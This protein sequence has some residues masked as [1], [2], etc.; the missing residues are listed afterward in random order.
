MNDQ[1]APRPPGPTGTYN[2]ATFEPLEPVTPTP[3]EEVAAVVELAREAQRGWAS[4]PFRERAD[5]VVSLARAVVERRA[6]IAGIAA[7]ESGRCETE[8]LVNE[9]ATNVTYA[10]SAVRAARGALAPETIK[11]PA[12][13]LPGKKVVVEAVPR[14]VIGIIAP[15]NYPLGNFF[16]SLYP[17][18]LAGDAAVLKPSSS[19]PRS[20]AWLA[21]LCAEIL[22]E[23]LV[24]IVQG[25]GAVAEALLDAGLDGVVFTGSVATG[26]RVAVKA[27]EL[28]IPCS[29][30]L[31][32][33]DAAV[34][35]A[36][37]NL[38]RT[39]AG[40]AQWSMHNCGQN[41][42][43]IERVY[44]EEA[45]AD[46]FVARLGAFVGALRV[47]PQDDGLADLG[48]VQNEAQ[49]RIV[50]RHVADA[51]ER[52][53]TVVCGGARTGRGLGYQPTVLDGCDASMLVVHEETFGPVVAVVRVADAEEALR[54]ANDVRYG[55]NASVWTADLARGAALARRFEAG[56]CYVN[57]HALGGTLPEIPWTGV[58][59]TGPGVAASRHSYPVF[60]R[61][62]TIFVDSNADPDPWWMPID[63]DL[64]EFADAL[65]T[66]ELGSFTVLLR[67][68]G[69]LKKRVAAIRGHGRG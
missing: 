61:R 36:D 37:C 10:R 67:L 24:G 5:K 64:T 56:V 68:L 12:L 39:V 13:D 63:A 25:G 21:A 35:L 15:W 8:A 22:G 52:G 26:R 46:D 48:A 3:P 43:A 44:V 65:A 20:G 18:L 7:A 47:F 53:A 16:K 11:L 29:V 49:L 51:V 14:G 45:I 2:P 59:E 6:E 58:K 62:Q 19:T 50:E 60:V 23:G 42:A 30:E 4:T 17:A 57:N 27:A 1:T 41:C 54:Q 38:D 55:L 40:I 9:I 34:V 31:G 33:K 66:K 32:G 28:L 69:L